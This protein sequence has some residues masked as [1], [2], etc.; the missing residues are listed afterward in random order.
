MLFALKIYPQT[1]WGEAFQGNF[2]KL[3]DVISKLGISNIITPVFQGSRL[4]FPEIN[5]DTPFDEKWNLLLFKKLC[6]ERNI[7]FIPEFPV[8][9]DPDTYERVQQYR[10]VSIRGEYEFPSSWYKPICPSNEQYRQYRL[11]LI[12]QALET[13]NPYLLNLD[14]LHYPYQPDIKAFEENGA[15]LPMYCYCDFCRYQFLDYSGHANPLEDIDGWYGFR[16]ENITLIP[17]LIKEELEKKGAKSNIMIQLPPVT[18]PLMVEKLRRLAGQDLNQWRG[19]VDILSPQIHLF[20]FGDN[21]EW[22]FNY[23]E[24]ILNFS[25]LRIMPEIDL[26]GASFDQEQLKVLKAAFSHFSKLGI[27]A[28]SLFHAEMLFKSEKLQDLIKSFSES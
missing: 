6:Q 13:F 28:M 7:G 21:L 26:P 8:F 2:E 10:P 25:D 22:S 16:S 11:N 23:V 18:S 12:F 3:L 14:F 17:I 24:E 4:F 19:L 27:S 20:Q 1:I 9:H 5:S 15:S